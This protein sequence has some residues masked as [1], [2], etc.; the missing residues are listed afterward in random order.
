MGKKAKQQ[1]IPGT[2]GPDRIDDIEKAA[3]KYRAVRDERMELTKK[4]T[5]AKAGLKAALIAHAKE[6]PKRAGADGPEQF[7]RCEDEEIE[8]VLVEG[9][10]DVKVKKHARPEDEEEDESE[11]EAA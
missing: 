2:E 9:D 11:E 10:Y 7:Y 4:E 8:A 1:K 6:L 3:A 5:Q